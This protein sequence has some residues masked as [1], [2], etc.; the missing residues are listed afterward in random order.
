MVI[1][2]LMLFYAIEDIILTNNYHISNN[3]KSISK[4]GKFLINYENSY[5]DVC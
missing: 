2:K 1:D 5:K 4:I 3:P